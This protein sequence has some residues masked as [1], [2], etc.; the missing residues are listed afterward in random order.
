MHSFT[1]QTN[2]AAK[3]RQILAI[4]EDT[5]SGRQEPSAAPAPAI[6]Q[7]PKPIEPKR[8]STP[9]PVPNPATPAPA[10]ATEPK[11]TSTP[12]P[13]PAAPT[14]AA[15]EAPAATPS[16]TPANPGGNGA[17]SPSP[18]GAN[19]PL[20]AE[21]MKAEMQMLVKDKKANVGVIKKI[22]QEVGGNS[23]I[24]NVAPEHYETIRQRW[25][26]EAI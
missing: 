2:D 22:N 14:P 3:A 5:P 19:S 20:T 26:S 24:T 18:A 10:P 9:A 12:A 11:K 7:P 23:L 21:A 4:L 16:P 25:H 13:A 15:P 17:V 6:P 1:F 8:T